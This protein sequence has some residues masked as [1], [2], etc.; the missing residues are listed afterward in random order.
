MGWWLF[1]AGGLLSAHSRAAQPQGVRAKM[2]PCAQRPGE[3]GVRLRKWPLEFL[4]NAELCL[5]VDR[6]HSCEEGRATRD[7]PERRPRPRKKGRDRDQR[8]PW[9]T[10]GAP[11]I[12]HSRAFDQIYRMHPSWILEHRLQ[13]HPVHESPAENSNRCFQSKKTS[14]K[15]QTP[16]CSDDGEK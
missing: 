7:P 5:R 10:C 8:R 14:S 11:E 15:R 9:E 1:G 3:Q 4:G 2:A 12:A 16:H 6:A 13:K